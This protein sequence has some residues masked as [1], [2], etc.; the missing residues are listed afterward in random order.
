MLVNDNAP[1]AKRPRL[2]VGTSPGAKGSSVSK[3]GKGEKSGKGVPASKSKSRQ[4]SAAVVHPLFEKMPLRQ[5]RLSHIAYLEK[6]IL[7]GDRSAFEQQVT[8]SDLAEVRWELHETNFRLELLFLDR[9]LRPDLWRVGEKAKDSDDA[10][11]LEAARVDRELLLRRVFPIVDGDTS[12]FFIKYMPNV[13]AGLASYDWQVRAEHIKALRE[14][15]LTWPNCPDVIKEA[16]LAKDEHTA[17]ILE[18]T[19]VKH[20]CAIFAEQFGRV[21]IPPR[22]LPDCSRRRTSP[23]TFYGSLF[24]VPRDEDVSM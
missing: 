3:K 24:A 2:A 19:V 13:D 7:L 18:N 1:H 14:V 20:Y 5:E 11:D 4:K 21:P 23:A 15:I 9:S 10:N 22:R 16:D 8:A 6:Q 17:A 12:G